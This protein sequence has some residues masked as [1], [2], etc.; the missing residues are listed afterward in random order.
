MKIGILT[1]YGDL[2]FGTN[3][4]AYATL[5]VVKSAYP[6]DEVS[7]IPLHTF[8]LRIIPYKSF[9]PISI[10]KDI[11][12]IRKYHKFKKYELGV[13]GKDPHY[14][15][16]DQAIKY[17]NS[18][19]YDRIY[20]GADTL[21]ELDRLKPDYDGISCYWLKDVNA[22]KFIIAASAKSTQ[23]EKLTSKQQT[24]L[25]IAASQMN[26]IAVRDRSTYNLF[27]NLVDESSIEMLPDPTFTMTI[28]YAP[29]EKYLKK[30]HVF[31]PQKSVYINCFGHDKWL[32]PVV[33]K[34][35]DSGYTIV[36]SRPMAWSDMSLNDIGPME[37]AGLLRY[38]DFAITQRFHEG[39]FCLKNKTPFLI[40]AG[41]G[42]TTSGGDSKQVSLVKDFGLYPQSYLGAT[43]QGIDVSNI[44]ERVKAVKEIFDNE[45][46]EVILHDNAYKYMDY[47]RRTM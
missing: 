36:T 42:F 39:V 46:I 30:K 10:W 28:D 13:R 23:F 8:W 1:Y 20:I 12:R 41:N 34:L 18:L 44:I 15:N 35:K 11:V 22:E 5:Q 40:F 33:A 37:Q 14:H 32:D 45:K 24:D 16:H 4:Q 7:I 26:K 6:N 17:I 21:L 29:I 2:N 9:S 31:I 43:D 27:A 25:K 3:L 47:L 38:F 19:G